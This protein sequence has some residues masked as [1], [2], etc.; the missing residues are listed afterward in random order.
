MKEEFD[1]LVAAGRIS[2]RHIA[3]LVALVSA[4]YCQH[5]S[6]GFGRIKTV[7]G[8]AGKLVVDFHLKPGH[9]L[10]L[11][12][13]ADSLKPI[14]KEHILARKHSD[15]EGLR[16]MAALHH[17]EVVK[18]V[19]MSYGGKATVDQVQQVLVPD[20]IQSD[21]K[22]WWETARSELKKDGH[23]MIP[24][25]KA[26]PIVYQT[27]ETS[28]ADRMSS[29][30][31]LAKGLKNRIAVAS[32][33]LRCT[34][35]LK[36]QPVL[37]EVLAGL[38]ADIG[39][40]IN[41]MPA[42]ALE[43]IF[44]RDDIRA[45]AGL[46]A[47]EGEVSAEA[48]WNK[49]HKL[50]ELFEEIPAAKHRKTLE[51]FKTFFPDWGAQ[52]LMLLNFVPAKLV[53][54]CARLLLQES[55]GQLLKDTLARLISRH[56]AGSELLLWFGKERNDFFADLLSPEVFR[57][58][59]TSIERDQFNE[60]KSN[61][62]RDFILEDQNLL[63]DLIEVADIDVI[64]DLVRTLQLSPSFDDMDKRSLLARV[65][66]QYP[67]VQS[68]ITGDTARQDHT[69]LVSWPSLERRKSE[70]EDLVQKR[71]PAN[72][73]DI[74]LARSYGDLREN[75]EYKAAK[76]MQK[77]LNRQKHELELMLSRARGTDFSTAKSDVAGPGTQVTLTDLDSGKVETI[78]LLGAWD[79][80][81]DQ[82]V[83]NYLTP[84]GQSLMNKPAGT[85]VEFKTEGGKRRIRV[86]AVGPI[87][88][89]LLPKAFV[90]KPAT[91]REPQS[92][93]EN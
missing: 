46:A 79:G 73:R 91:P 48:V 29:D 12:F 27:Q 18:V 25:K 2:S 40:H 24:M 3:P 32:E 31:R 89:E 26:D 52:V 30:F 84:L 41:T 81:P 51:S 64:K 36:G 4:G 44:M 5:K 7:D 33:V 28:L 11:Q 80:D 42:L 50:P 93:T 47:S 8:V 35:D 76:E 58:M 19:L 86:D 22:K 87:P 13:A 55:R 67:V 54:E 88:A 75:H 6:W 1:Q 34:E 78:S 15:L 20:V 56:E 49:G 60:R 92:E 45:A 83:I 70:Y 39:S 71:I 21:W 16:K 43:G 74:A 90:E 61:R 68:M 62:L 9:Q 82:S 14:S 85:E 57:A 38:N 37:I 53:G 59:M 66:K 63:P 72:V 17:L 23:F 10:E 65:V 77:V 69:F